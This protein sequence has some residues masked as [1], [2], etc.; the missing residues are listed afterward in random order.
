MLAI[1]G[2][3]GD[4]GRTVLSF[5]Q[6]LHYARALLREPILNGSSA[7]AI[8]E[9]TANRAAI[10][11]DTVERT[12]FAYPDSPY[13]PLLEMARVDLPRLKTLVAERGVEGTLHRLAGDGVHVSIEEF[14]GRRELQRG[15]LRYRVAGSAFRNP[16]IASGL[17]AS[18][19][20]TRSRGL[21]TTI[22]PANHQRGAQHLMFALSAYGL[23][24][25]PVIVWLAY[26]HG[27]SLWAVLALL[28]AGNPVPYWFSQVPVGTAARRE[29]YAR[30]LGI[31]AS[32]SLH[33]ARLP[34][35]THV[36]IGQEASLVGRV[37]DEIR[38]RQRCGVFTTPSAALRLALA[39]K[40]AGTTL[41]GVTFVTIAEPL[42]PAK[43]AAIRTAGAEA[44][45]S[46]GFTELGRATYGCARP[47]GID[48]GHVCL[49]LTAVIERRR[50]V[51]R[52]GTEVDAL[53]FTALGAD[54]RSILLNVETGDYARLTTRRC[55]CPFETLGWTQHMRDIRSF[56]KLNAEGPPFSGSKLIS[57]VEEI[58]PERFGGDGTDYQLLEEEDHEGF[59]RLSILVHPRLGAIDETKVLAC[60]FEQ[61]WTTGKIG[62]R[63]WAEAGTVNVRRAEPML[64]KAGKLLPLHHL[65]VDA[66]T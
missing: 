12:I 28:A 37:V 27:A 52:A 66:G 64:T 48:D 35:A 43:M 1:R 47:D 55:G 31:R 2:G 56:E 58:F 21:A 46:L 15:D 11:V 19:G 3:V 61:L 59:T 14:K 24:N 9:R 36:P 39:A 38:K 50:A 30:Y 26:A 8:R 17:V 45:S 51:D 20:G 40:R 5:A 18:S 13:R 7:A 22:S 57:L 10:F 60:A 41:E 49:D 62:A 32:A 34:S 65:S 33:R 53:L 44:Y 29:V 16:I 42:T 6:G 4:L 54:S 63:V 23:Q 25:A